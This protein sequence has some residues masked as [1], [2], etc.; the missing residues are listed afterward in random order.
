[1]Y[2]TAYT[3]INESTKGAA[4]IRVLLASE[5]PM[6]R[7]EVAT[8]V[9]CSVGRVGEIIHALNHERTVI[10]SP[11]K[12]LYTVAKRVPLKALPTDTNGRSVAA[13]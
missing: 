3:A 6:S 8:E 4:V 5:R 12:G 2:T 9:G 1:M 10:E 11:A 7:R 13:V